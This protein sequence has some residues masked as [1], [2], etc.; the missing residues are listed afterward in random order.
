[1]VSRIFSLLVPVRVTAAYATALFVIASILVALGPRTT[2]RVIG[3][4]STNLDNLGSGHLATLVGSAFVTEEGQTYLLLPGLI[5][6]LALAE[7]LWCGRRVV[8]AFVLGHLGAT[9]IVAA[10][11]VAAIEAGWVSRSIEGASDVGL[12][13]G[14]VAVLGALSA[15]IPARWRAAWIGGWLMVALSVVALGAGFVAIGHAV[16]LILGM[17]LSTR[18]HLDVHWTGLRRSLLPAAVGFGLLLLVGVA[19]PTAPIVIPAGV[20]GAAVAHV[21]VASWRAAADRR[22]AVPAAR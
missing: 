8:Q 22:T 19:L 12:S 20:L 1:M 9:L 2:E 10:G 14:A 16:A 4:L 11:L 6:L 13:Y 3:Q 18:F 15:A 5:C 7:L 17:A 21:V